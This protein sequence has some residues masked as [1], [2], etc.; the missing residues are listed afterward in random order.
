MDENPIDEM[1]NRKQLDYP[2]FVLFMAKITSTFDVF[3][4]PGML[5]TLMRKGWRDLNKGE[6][7]TIKID[8][9]S[10]KEEQLIEKKFEFLFEEGDIICNPNYITFGNSL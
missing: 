6:P 3:Q 4:E 1:K 10:C 5:D 8:C 7:F 2:E 9:P